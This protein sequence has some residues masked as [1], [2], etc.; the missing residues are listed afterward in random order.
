MCVMPIHCHLAHLPGKRGREE[1][2]LTGVMRTMVAPG[3]MSFFMTIPVFC[4][5][6]TEGIPGSAW[7]RGLDMMMRAS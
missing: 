2:T 4:A 3:V 5:T 6:N 1:R 7:S